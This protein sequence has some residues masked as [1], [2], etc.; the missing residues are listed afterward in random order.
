MSSPLPREAQRSRDKGRVEHSK[1]IR[2]A[3]EE[4]SKKLQPSESDRVEE[5][6]GDYWPTVALLD[7]VR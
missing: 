6:I 2:R 1:S 3:F 4:H 7:T 5:I